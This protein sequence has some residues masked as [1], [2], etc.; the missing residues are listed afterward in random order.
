M[1]ML[2][3]GTGEYGPL[4]SG[5][6]TGVLMRHAS[7]C[8]ARKLNG[9]VYTP[10]VLAD[11]V[12][13]KVA[14]L[15]AQDHLVGAEPEC[16]DR[17]V[18]QILDPACGD[19]ELLAAI[20]RHMV[21]KTS[22]Q[23]PADSAPAD[24]ESH[25]VICGVDMDPNAVHRTQLRMQALPSRS[26]D[27]DASCVVLNTNALFPV[28]GKSSSEGWAEVC[29]KLG[30]PDGFDIIIAN[31]PWGADVDAYRAQL[32]GGEFAMCRGQFDTADLFVELGL[33]IAKPGGYLAFIL[34]DSLFALERAR[35]R[36][37]LLDRSHVRFIGRFGE[38]IFRNV[39]RACAVIICRKQ[40]A[41]G[42]GYTQCLRLTPALRRSIIGGRSSFA[43]AEQSLSH[44]VLQ[45][46]FRRNRHYL[47]DIDARADEEATLARFRG[48]SGRVADYLTSSRGV[49]LSKRGRVQQCACCGLWFPVPTGN[50]PR[51]VHCREPV[52]PSAGVIETAVSPQ[53]R[54][55]MSPFLVG[56]SV[57]R[58]RIGRRLWL[59]TGYAGLNYKSPP[60]Y[61]AP[62]LLV[63]KTGVGISAALDYSSA[64]T[65]Q[66]V[67][68]FR[69]HDLFRDDVPLE[70][71]LG[72]LNSRAMYY[73][74]AKTYGETEWRSHPYVTQKHILDLPLPDLR[75][76]ANADVARA[77]ADLL[78]PFAAQEL[79]LP[80]AV[81]AQVEE[82]V[83]EL[84]GLTRGDYQSI[85]ETLANAEQLLPIRELR[86]VPPED[87]FG[88]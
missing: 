13:G 15:Y 4:Q 30:T 78:S 20:W 61:A 7:A 27:G 63:R 84:Y 81:D 42:S 24:C 37:L 5:L 70:T 22:T 75:V 33:N 19:G 50:A 58:Y 36:K 79:D 83:A 43:Q 38:R 76:S 74:L 8:D 1:E 73:F 9:A 55:G 66:V 6:Q 77:I 49:E 2:W 52:P 28:E 25:T 16:V 56:E 46:H 53:Q 35:L 57:G 85:Y 32:G 71:F 34:P 60:T 59:D 26:R 14:E 31:P 67:Y 51:C 3:D 21:N 88:M 72:V 44:S 68:I 62:K 80:C 11:Y 45:E 40:P 12:A 23:L 69:Q 64:Y 18:L 41:A 54:D 10:S 47:F 17:R 39:N 48:L 29:E 87:I 65:N 82:L 86:R